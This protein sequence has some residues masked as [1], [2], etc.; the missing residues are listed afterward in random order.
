[1]TQTPYIDEEELKRLEAENAAIEAGLGPT[2]DPKTAAPTTFKEPTPQENR[3]AGN[4]QPVK[5]P[6]DQALGQMGLGQPQPK[7][8][9][10]QPANRGSG[11]IYGSGDA[12]ATLA[13]DLGDY[14]TRVFEGLGAAGA[15]LIDFGMDA[16]G[17]IKGA[18]QIDDTWDAQTKFKNPVFRQVREAA[19]TILPS[20]MLGKAT[21]GMIG[22]GIQKGLAALGINAA[23]E[24]AIISVSDQGTDDNLST[25]VSKAAPWIP[26]PEQLVIQDD[27]S[28][29]VRR[30]KNQYEAAGT[31]IVADLLGFAFGARKAV[32]GW[33]EPKD[34]TAKAYKASEAMV[35]ADPAT[36]TA[37]SE[38]STRVDEAD[39][40]A[41]ET[42]ALIE[43]AQR[44]GV[45]PVEV[46]QM[47]NGLLE[48]TRA[49][50]E[51]SKQADELTAEYLSTG[52]SRLTEDPL[53][54]YVTRQ[55]TS[56]DLQIDEVGKGRLL[57]DPGGA[58]GVDPA[59]TPHLFPEGSTAALS[60]PPGHVARNAA[61]VAAIKYGTSKGTPAPL[62]SERAYYDLSKGNTVSRNHI[63]DLA[64]ATRSAGNFDAVV[65]GFRYT[66]AQMSD[67]AWKIYNDVVLART[68]D[69]TKKLF[70]DAR[71]VKH[72][73]DGRA[74]KYVNDVQAEAIAFAMRDLTDKYLGRVVNETSARAMD[75]TA[76][77]V[78]DIAAAY[79]AMPE[80]A[81]Y[82][83]ITEM[84]GDR[85]A[86]LM[87]EYGLNKYIAG[88]ALKNQDRWQKLLKSAPDK[89]VAIEEITRQFD[90]KVQEKHAQAQNYRNMISTIAKERP[91]AA[92]VLI[93][94]FAASG[95]DVDTYDKLLKWT[96]Q[97]VSPVGLLKGVDGGLNAFAQGAF[98]I[99]YGNMLSGLSALKAITG[100]Q[101]LLNLRGINTA[102]GT[103]LGM[104][105][106]KNT[107]Q[108]FR[109]SIHVWSAMNGTNQRALA[110][111]WQSY[112]GLWNN[113]KWGDDAVMDFKDLAREDLVLDYNPTIWDTLEGME[114]VWE[115]NGDWGKLMQYRAARFMYDL[116]N[117]RWLKYGTNMMIGNDAYAQTTIAIQHARFQAY[118]EVIGMG[119]KGEQLQ[120]QLAKAEK[121]A[122][123]EM[124]DSAG[125]VKDSFV[126]YASGEIALNLDDEMA[127]KL[128]M[129]TSQIPPLKTLF[130]FPKTGVNAAKLAASYTP[131]AM[132]PGSSRYSK[133]L[134]AGNDLDLIKEALEEHGIIYDATPN[135]MA[136]F[137]GLEAEY[138]GR[139]AFGSLLAGGLFNYAIGGNIRGNGPVNPSER[140]KLRDNFGWEQKTIN[141]GGKW[142]SYAGLEPLDTVL[143]LIGDLAYYA[144][145]IG[146]PMMED[147]TT[148]LGWTFAATFVNKT[149]MAGLEPLVAIL[150][151]DET[152]IQRLLAN[153]VR[154]Y[155]PWSGAL[156]VASNAI[157][158]SQKDIY[159]D[160]IGY[161]KNRLPGLSSSLP[162]RIDIFTGQPLNDIENPFLRIVNAVNPVKVGEG[163]EP[164]RQWLINT[165]WDGMQMIR[166][167]STGNHEYTPAEREVLYRY[168]GEQQ[169]WKQYEKLSQNKKYNDQLDRV[170]AMRVQGRSSEE[171][172]V[173]QL[174]AYTVLNQILTDAQKIAE[175]RLQTD[176]PA[177]WNGIQEAIRTKNYMKQ[178]RVDD[179]A[180]AADRRK[181]QI[182]VLTTQMYR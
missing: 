182:E 46:D 33:F 168:I 115:K 176:N 98:A 20:I 140:K 61:D 18:E 62:L 82:D 124:F 160:M 32:M 141:I 99:R 177:I 104:L 63:V 5:S 50:K 74:I 69:D 6:K 34:D 137:K 80:T 122:Y 108:D 125:N 95:G 133:V 163:T 154:S 152:A 89:Q 173:A 79:K 31:S 48:Q 94:A 60:I 66:K 27:D 22:G 130:M 36:A 146:S 149:F 41:Q 92:Q 37:L 15:G 153:E 145:D 49:S 91:D 71:D 90:V 54:S 39:T 44:Q 59:I 65:D 164:W 67:A 68:V 111:A 158:S 134:W 51:L 85:L 131:L 25:I 101:L 172:E 56:R 7:T 81:D 4:V 58:S 132:L 45:D 52:A 129:I 151:Q 93:D 109:R 97:Q 12:N 148:K 127:S 155:I 126:K 38:I 23:G 105:M 96:A 110:D 29:E 10:Q 83:R 179:A 42:A 117:W 103:G 1:M 175:Q 47:V 102:L 17:R 88:W 73:L 13:E 135:A 8:P 55:Q 167:D 78:T 120:E 9:T 2:Y 11:F 162:E 118:E 77:E 147:Y 87:E 112:K 57:D 116:G 143:T 136:V 26:V 150:N 171:I 75:T 28:P 139:V 138:R 3:A 180:R 43:I 181:Q 178:G 170:R 72:L 35:N 128:S 169:I 100:S 121:L 16:I 19:S 107:P 64:E 119:Y 144:T 76:R 123:G 24:A 84:M 156:G 86:F 113:G 30:Q 166:M 106:G 142:V 174:E 40:A 114:K 53:D 21:G 14:A 157:T 165:G 159:N 70:L 161:V